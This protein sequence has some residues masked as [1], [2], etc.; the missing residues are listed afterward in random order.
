MTFVIAAPE[1]L[2]AAALDLAGYRSALSAA[3]AAA[4]AATTQVQAAASDEVSIAISALFRDYAQ[5]YQA[6]S[7][8][9]AAFHSD[10]VAHLNAAAASYAS[11]EA[12]LEQTLLSALNARSEKLLG[13]PMIG[14]GANGTAAQPDGGAGGLLYGNG[15]NG[16]SH[17]G[18]GG[19][20]GNGGPAGLIGNGGAGGA[21]THGG[22]GGVGGWLFGNGGPGGNGGTGGN[23][24]NGG[25]AGLIGIGGA[26]GVGGS[27]AHGG[28]GG[29]G[30]FVFG[31]GGARGERGGAPSLFTNPPPPSP[32]QDHDAG[33]RF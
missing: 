5:L 2:S 25:A 15:G 23:A 13:R 1:A 11:T 24:G 7:A 3:D 29:A 6:L 8:Q 14:D 12:A 18:A 27:G 10:L 9:A 32:D 22:A 28:A 20:A 4:A 21:G 31:K 19:A 33:F 16:Y 17:T 26:G 30:G